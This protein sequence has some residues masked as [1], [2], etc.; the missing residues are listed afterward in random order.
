MPALGKKS[1][2]CVCAV[3]AHTVLAGN[4]ICGIFKSRA[5]PFT[6]RIKSGLE[7]VGTWLVSSLSLVKKGAV[8][9]D[10]KAHGF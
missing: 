8:F 1:K 7:D 5:T 9:E 6:T 10:Y 4:G 3:L 2:E